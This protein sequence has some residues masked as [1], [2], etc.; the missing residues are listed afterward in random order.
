M[1][2]HQAIIESVQGGVLPNHSEWYVDLKENHRLWATHNWFDF[3]KIHL[4]KENTSEILNSNCFNDGKTID[5][6]Q[7]NLKHYGT[8]TNQLVLVL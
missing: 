5:Y 3:P 4:E 7:Q 8:S 1:G 2:D 6:L